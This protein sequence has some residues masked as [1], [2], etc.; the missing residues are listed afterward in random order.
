MS[1]LRRFQA[2]LAFPLKHLINQADVQFYWEDEF[3]DYTF[4]VNVLK[5]ISPSPC[6][7]YNRKIILASYPGKSNFVTRYT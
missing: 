7:K 6:S 3:T 2:G 4:R 1:L 5:S